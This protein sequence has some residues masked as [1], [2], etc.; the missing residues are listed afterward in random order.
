MTFDFFYGSQSES[1]SFY[2]IPRLLITDPAFRC[3]SA[4]AKLLYGLLLDRMSLSARSGWY[5]EQNR[6]FIYY[7][8]EEI[9][10]DMCCGHD[11]VTKLLREL[12]AVTGI[13]LIERVKQGLGKP[14]RIYVKAFFPPRESRTP[15]CGDV[16]VKTAENPQQV[17]W[18]MYSTPWRR[19][20]RRSPTCGSTF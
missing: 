4:D 7:T 19:L 12:D 14:T 17:M 11:K 18:S 10:Q 8:M 1:F 6:V 16:A 9:G 20:R 3:L 15:D 5:D 2:R 13:G